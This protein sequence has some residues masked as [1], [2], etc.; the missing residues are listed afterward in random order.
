ME[1]LTERIAVRTE[2]L[3]Q[4]AELDQPEHVVR[5]LGSPKPLGKRPHVRTVIIVRFVA[6]VRRD[7]R[8]NAAAL[9]RPTGDRSGHR[10]VIVP[11]CRAVE[12]DL[13]TTA[14]GGELDEMQIDLSPVSVGESHGG[15][16]PVLDDLESGTDKWL[17]HPVNRL[18]VD[19][20]SKSRCSLVCR[21]MSASTPIPRQPIPSRGLPPDDRENR[22]PARLAPQDAGKRSG[23]EERLG[24][25][26]GSDIQPAV[27]NSLCRARCRC[28]AAGAGSFGAGA[29]PWSSH[30]GLRAT[31]WNVYK[32]LDVSLDPAGPDALFDLAAEFLTRAALVL[33]AG[34]RD[35][36][37]LIELVRRFDVEGVGVE[38]VALHVDRARAAV[39]A[40]DLRDRITLHQ[41]VMHELDHADG[42]D[43]VW[44]RDV[45][46]RW[47]MSTEH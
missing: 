42:L 26:G 31:T 6:Q 10:R 40:A 3:A 14:I 32:T 12:L 13:I 47:T 19:D 5:L 17:S 9:D 1:S 34:S 30:S 37:H 8:V 21:P 7:L 46:S 43:L 11:S 27:R 15:R 33:D 41:G 23:P 4:R 36:A 16:Q 24:T 18:G 44:C 38:P 29:Q 39:D 22:R 20:E 2:E 45:L 35:A 28:V 25:A